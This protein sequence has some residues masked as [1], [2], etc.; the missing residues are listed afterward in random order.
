MLGGPEGETILAYSLPNG[1]WLMLQAAVRNL[2]ETLPPAS[3]QP[4]TGRA[5]VTDAQVEAAARAI[6]TSRGVDPDT[7]FQIN[8]F[9]GDEPFD[10][11]DD[12]GRRFTW[13]WRKN[14]DAARAALNAALTVQPEAGE[15]ADSD[16]AEALSIQLWRHLDVQV[17]ASKAEMIL[18][19]ARAALDHHARIVRLSRHERADGIAGEGRSGDRT[20][21][22]VGSLAAQLDDNSSCWAL[23]S[24]EDWV[25]ASIKFDWA[26]PKLTASIDAALALVE[27][28]LPGMW[29]CMSKGRLSEGEPLFACELLFGFDERVSIAEGQTLPIAIIAALLRALI[30]RTPDTGEGKP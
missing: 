18:R 6:T 5:G 7:L 11:E 8:I 28:M 1:L 10:K 24:R 22:G 3:P 9:T 14:T 29:W 4:H 13:A 20:G 27:R 30:V 12:R 15:V 2:L 16:L 25:A 23:W 19:D 26:S 17:T 21:S